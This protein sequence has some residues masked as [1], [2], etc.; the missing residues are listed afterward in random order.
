MSRA[1]LYDSTMC[2]GCRECERACATRWSHPY[3]DKIASEEKISAHKFVAI[4]TRGDK[5]SRRSC[6]HC[7]EPT[8]ASVCP[9]GAMQK[10]ALGPVVYD[11]TKCIGCRYCMQACPFQVPTYEWTAR[12]PRVRKCSMCADRQEKGLLTACA[13][14]CP[15]GATKCGDRDELIAEAKKR[16]TDK[17][18]EYYQRI[19]GMQEVG[20]TSVLYIAAVPFDKIGLKTEVPQEPLPALTW[21]A[22]S[23]VPDV[24]MVGSTLLGGV[25]WITHRRQK[26]AA[27]EA[28][29]R[30]AAKGGR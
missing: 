30:K 5:Y 26:V 10:T 21:R 2:V 23:L 4:Q 15:T 3:D 14:A 1:I 27:E 20:G 17:P 11:E 28:A 6:M 24:A 22:L 13:E 9:V 16:L 19:Y 29:E 7:V 8:C 18:A 12:L 25:Y